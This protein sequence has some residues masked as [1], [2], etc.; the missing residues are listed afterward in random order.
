MN[1]HRAKRGLLVAYEIYRRLE[2][3]VFSIHRAVL[4]RRSLDVGKVRFPASPR[5]RG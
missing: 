4:I 5:V 2:Y 1:D 3:R